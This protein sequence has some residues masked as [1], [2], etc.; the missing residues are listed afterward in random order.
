MIKLIDINTII[1]VSITLFVNANLS[2]LPIITKPC[3]RLMHS[4]FAIPITHEFI[5]MSK[6][7]SYFNFLIPLPHQG[8]CCSDNL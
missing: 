2:S 6:A 1:R 4:T 7:I 8:Y 5:R 3:L